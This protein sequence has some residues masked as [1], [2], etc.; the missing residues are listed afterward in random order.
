MTL[1]KKG[2]LI[3]LA[4]PMRGIPNNNVPLFN[5]VANRLRESGYRVFNPG[6]NEKA[7]PNP[8]F[9]N[10]MR[11]DIAAILKADAV[12]F[13]RGWPQSEGASIEYIVARA[14]GLPR[15]WVSETGSLSVLVDLVPKFT[16]EDFLAHHPGV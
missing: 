6:E 3:Y 5:N 7:I 1:P 9:S 14:L 16:I 8:T 2:S 11:L 13:L 12:A 10:F 15:L 4:G